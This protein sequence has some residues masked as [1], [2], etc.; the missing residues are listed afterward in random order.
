MQLEF[1]D[2][3]MGK[4]PTRRSHQTIL[5]WQLPASKKRQSS[6]LPN[7]MFFAD[8]RKLAKERAQLTKGVHVPKPSS[9]G[10][11]HHLGNGHSRF[12]D[13]C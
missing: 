7:S 4:L 9:S 13:N 10:A 1:N 12:R 11:N 5:K 2:Y 8:P 3:T 6:T